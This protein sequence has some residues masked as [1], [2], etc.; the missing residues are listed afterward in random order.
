MNRIERTVIQPELKGEL[1]KLEHE[2][3]WVP[4]S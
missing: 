4:T 1:L 2:Y 3:P